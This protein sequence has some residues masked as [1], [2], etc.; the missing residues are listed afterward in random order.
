MNA[1]N[2]IAMP[3][4]LLRVRKEGHKWFFVQLR[5]VFY[6]PTGKPVKLKDRWLNYGLTK[7]K[8]RI[9]LFRLKAGRDGH[10][11]VDM[12]EKKYYYCGLEYS[13]FKAKLLD[14]GIG[15]RE[16]RS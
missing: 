4:H 7:D 14:L 3:I 5:E 12:R 10:Y 16:P 15:R 2:E 9:E 6:N 1:Q 11:L 8:I 13:Q